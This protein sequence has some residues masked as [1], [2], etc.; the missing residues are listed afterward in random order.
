[1]NSNITLVVSSCDKYEDLWHPFFQLLK[2]YWDPDFPILLITESKDFAYP[3]LNIQTLHLYK[4]GERPEW[5]ELQMKSLEQIHT[6]LV[7]FMLD[8]FFINDYVNKGRI[9]ETAQW[10]EQ[11]PSIACFC[12]APIMHGKNLPC[13]YHGFE[14]RPQ[15]GEYRLNAQTALWRRETL[16]HDM[17]PHENAWVFETL[18]SMRSFRYK[19]QKFY[20]ALPDNIIVPYD[21]QDGGALNHGKWNP[22][23]VELNEKEQLGIDISARGINTEE[24]GSRERR[25]QYLSDWSWKRV[26]KAI[27]TRWRS[28]KW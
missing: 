10:M 27:A 1:M 4:P 9:L 25:K 20:A 17:R 23:A 12:F 18:G 3:G 6:D 28:L 16:L 5:S 26:S 7:L 11:D 24:R 13:G 2:K 22:S 19:D 14:L 15:K 8:D 21:F